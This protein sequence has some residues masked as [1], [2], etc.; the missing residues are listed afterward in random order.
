MGCQCKPQVGGKFWCGDG[1][2]HDVILSYWNFIVSLTGDCK[3]FYRIPLFPI[4]LLFYLFCIY[5]DWQGQKCKLKCPMRLSL[6]YIITVISDCTHSYHTNTFTHNLTRVHL[7][8]L[9]IHNI[10]MK[11]F[12]N[13]KVFHLDI[14]EISTLKL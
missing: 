14:K 9:K 6:N 5:W 8:Q 1:I 3:R 2:F 11:F 7:L 12:W 10:W 4:F 13:Q